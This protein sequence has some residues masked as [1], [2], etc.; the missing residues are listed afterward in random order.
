M[1]LS[2]SNLYRVILRDLCEKY[3]QKLPFLLHKIEQWQIFCFHLVKKNWILSMK[4]SDL[5]L[6][7]TKSLFTT[8]QWMSGH[9]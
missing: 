3:M 7:I 2:E 8:V 9:L 6:Y 5:E 1:E 4:A